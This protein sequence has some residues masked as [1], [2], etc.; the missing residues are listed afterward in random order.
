MEKI[1]LTSLLS[2][3]L[4]ATQVSAS[5]SYVCVAD[6]GTGFDYD[7]TINKWKIVGINVDKDKFIVSK[8]TKDSTNLIKKLKKSG[9]I[10]PFPEGK[11]LWSVKHVDDPLAM[12]YCK[13]DFNKYGLLACEGL[14]SEFKMNKNNLRFIMTS[15]VGY[16]LGLAKHIPKEKEIG[17]RKS[18]E[19]KINHPSISLG[20]CSAL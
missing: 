9:F 8:P 19:K 14:F 18:L 11:F 4:L 1:I 16:H 5:E 7:K 2:C 10:A 17:I 12:I 13:K 6:I 20:K 15:S 3:F